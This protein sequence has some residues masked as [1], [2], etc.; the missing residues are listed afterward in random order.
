[1]ELKRLLAAPDPLPALR[2][3]LETRVMG[4]ALPEWGGFAPIETLAAHGAPADPLMRV[5]ALVCPGDDVIVPLALARRLRLSK[6]ERDRLI[7]LAAVPSRD[8][9]AGG[10]PDL[11][12]RRWLARC[13]SPE[14]ARDALWM[15]EARDGRDRAALRTRIAAMPM[16]VFPLQGRDLLALGVSPGPEV[17]RMLSDLRAWWIAEGAGPDGEACL[18]EA[19]RRLG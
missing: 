3:M 10:E 9:P 7:R 14:A 5:A 8:T 19:R 11:A 18:A 2:L 16:P 6:E 15:A 17:G 12:L 4:A 1:M 13:G